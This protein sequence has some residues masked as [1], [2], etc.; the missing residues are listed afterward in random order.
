MYCIIAKV[1][2]LLA[3]SEQMYIY[4]FIFARLLQLDIIKKQTITKDYWGFLKIIH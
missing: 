1:V 2:S 3:K 4:F